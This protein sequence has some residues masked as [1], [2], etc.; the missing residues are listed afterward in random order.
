MLLHEKMRLQRKVNKLTLRQLKASN[1]KER[2]T[3]NIARVQKMYSSKMTQLEKQGQM[4]QNQASMAFRNMFGLGM[5]NQ[6]FDPFCF[7][8]NGG[9]GVLSAVFNVAQGWDGINNPMTNKPFM[10]QDGNNIFDGAGGKELL[11][12]YLQGAI[13]QKV[14]DGKVVP[15]EYYNEATQQDVSAAQY[16]ALQTCSNYANSQVQR[17]NTMCSQMTSQYQSNVS[18]WLEAAKA[19]LDAEQDAALAPLELEETEMDLERESCEAQL[20]DAKARLESIKQA[21]SEGI[22]DSAPTFGLG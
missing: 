16:S 7:N 22:K 20:A 9:P 3:K 18:I 17:M 13:R 4:F 1:R 6:T 15:G 5:Q 19:Q 21:C 14:V 12:H 10:D 11:M 8:N 2:I